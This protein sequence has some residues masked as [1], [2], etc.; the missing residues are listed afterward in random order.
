MK[1]A[2]PGMMGQDSVP[3]ASGKKLKNGL[4]FTVGLTYSR[5]QCYAAY[6]SLCQPAGSLVGL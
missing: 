6:W 3:L 1:G 5:S 2:M 4:W